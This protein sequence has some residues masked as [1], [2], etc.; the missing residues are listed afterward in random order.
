M[1]EETHES[2]MMQR[3]ER[4]ESRLRWTTGIGIA[5]AVV[6]AALLLLFRFAG[7]TRVS[8]Q[9][10]VLT[11]ALGEPAARLAFLPEGPGL[12]IDTPAGSPRVKLVGGP[13]DAMLELYLPKTSEL[14]FASMNIYHGD[15]QIYS[16]RAG[17]S[18]STLKMSSAADNSVAS[19]S[20]LDGVA[21]F[22]L[23]GAGDRVP[24]LALDAARD[25]ACATL[26]MGE[27][28][29][30]RGTFCFHSPGLPVLELTDFA[31]NEAILGSESS[32]RSRAG[33]A[34]PH[35]AVSLALKEKDGKILRV[36]PR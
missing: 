30:S 19:L 20:L 1:R 31:G 11:N 4:L 3:V 15:T 27:N 29:P 12:E 21:S 35:A 25:H 34:P 16:V 22:G 23:A 28:S 13:E 24:R 26:D 7:Y 8:A 14:G 18:G 36:A 6:L 33:E 2:E 5:L 9:E 32:A 10:F 17:L